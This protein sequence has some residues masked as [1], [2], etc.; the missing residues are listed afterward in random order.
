MDPVLDEVIRRSAKEDQFIRQLAKLAVE[1]RP[2]VGLLKDAVVH[3][4]GK[5]AD[6]FDVKQG[7]IAPITNLARVLS[8]ESGFTENRTLRR[9]RAAAGAGRLEQ[10]TL[11]GLEEAFDLL[12]QIRVERQTR[13]VEEGAMPDDSVRPEW[14]GPLTRQALREAFQLIDRAQERLAAGLGLRR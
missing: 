6:A 1:A 2:P 8:V 3:P 4:R 12:W 11:E 7:G 10:E 13:A 14:L 9:L 5:S